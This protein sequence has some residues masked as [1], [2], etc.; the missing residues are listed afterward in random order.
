[1][2]V[3]GLHG[4]STRLALAALLLL[5][6][7]TGDDDS[8]PAPTTTLPTG[9]LDGGAVRLGLPGPLVLDPV[10]ANPGSP[11]ELM[12]ADLLH[13]GLTELGADGEIRPGLAARWSADESFQ[14]W[15]FELDD[16]ATFTDGS[17]VTAEAVAASLTRVAASGPGTLAS[18]RLEAVAG[19]PEL[20]A[21]AADTLS[22][23]SAEGD[24]TVRIQTTTPLATLPAIL[25]AP[26]LGIVAPEAVEA[27]AAAE[28]PEDLDQL[29]DVP[30]SGRWEPSGAD[31]GAL[32]VTRRRRA[33]GHLDAV[34]LEPFDDPSAAYSA[35]EAG[36]VDWALVPG[37][38]HDE[39]VDAHGDDHF[40][41]FHAEVF[42]GLRVTGPPLDSM[43]L[44]VAVAAA[45][46]R[47]ELVAEVYADVAD[48]LSTVVP[49]GVPGH[50]PDVC[51][52]AD[53]C[54]YD[55]EVAEAVLAEAHPDGA[56]PTVAIDFDDSERQ[57][58]LAEEV[59][60]ALDAVGIPTELRPRPRGEYRAFVT[61]GQQQ[62]FSLGWIGGY[63]SPDA[64]L[65]PL[66]G[67]T[68]DD[69]LTGVA[70]ATVDQALA[71]ARATGDPE[72][73]E[74]AWSG[75][76]AQILA[77]AIVV[78][79]AQFRTQAVAAERVQ[80]LRH[81]IDGSVDWAAVWVLDAAS[82]G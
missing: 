3:G 42:L 68:A 53:A 61:S 69:N 41:P 56:V 71:A 43:S 51:G 11:A 31:E 75:V 10:A 38:D 33:S 22:G 7:C 30:L 66:F 17:P 39:A 52:D 81:R 62:L 16:D 21:G 63:P 5:T 48:P 28:D 26:E 12:V 13:D 35:F 14:S 70:S 23:V 79:V 9:P 25:A 46:D 29:E 78:P 45:I 80:D 59:A 40:S 54:R 50:D 67:S 73:A 72:A 57:T 60:A 58:R 18:L 82:E 49:V 47:D 74:A 6:G 24:G 55:P 77:E 27:L 44:R 20:V 37:S 8:Q 34:V 1:M 64:Y 4:T 15:T 2:A 19:H 76:E 32:T 65:A 36:D